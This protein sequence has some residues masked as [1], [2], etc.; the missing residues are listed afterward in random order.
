MSEPV[1]ASDVGRLDAYQV[2]VAHGL[3]QAGVAVHDLPG[4]CFT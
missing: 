2:T 4:A 3:E 1:G